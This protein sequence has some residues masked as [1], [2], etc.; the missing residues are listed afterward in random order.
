LALRLKRTISEIEEISLN[1][2]NE[3]IA[4]FTLIEERDKNE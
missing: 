1:E 4:Y 3:W 2:Y